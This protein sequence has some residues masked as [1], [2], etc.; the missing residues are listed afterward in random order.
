M[1][2]DDQKYLDLVASLGCIICKRPAEIHHIRAGMGIAQRNNNRR[3][4]PLCPD[5]HRNGG[6]G[7][8]IHAGRASWE[9]KFG[10]EHMLWDRLNGLIEIEKSRTG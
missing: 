10:T 1:T 7:V 3:V 8:A 4:L 5:H 9:N 2:K 6:H